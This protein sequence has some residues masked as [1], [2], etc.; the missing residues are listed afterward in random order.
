MTL[1]RK[2]ALLPCPVWTALH[3]SDLELTCTSPPQSGPG[4]LCL[5][6][7][8]AQVTAS[9]ELVRHDHQ[10]SKLEPGRL[11]SATAE[12]KPILFIGLQFTKYLAAI[13]L[14]IVRLSAFGLLAA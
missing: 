2:G 6:C 11:I 1:I 7:D 4:R 8:P 12:Q 14:A 10:A 3:H 5:R 9:V 13:N